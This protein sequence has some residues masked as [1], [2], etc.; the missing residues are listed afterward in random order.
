RW[1]SDRKLSAILWEPFRMGEGTRPAG[2]LVNPRSFRIQAPCRG[3]EPPIPP[4]PPSSHRR[5]RGI[6]RATARYALHRPAPAARMTETV[7]APPASTTAIASD[8]DARAR[9]PAGPG[10]ARGVAPAGSTALLRWNAP[11]LFSKRE[12]H[13]GNAA[14]VAPT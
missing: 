8:R 10:D 7:P 3:R 2:P 6:V 4:G 13:P 9:T 11:W 14:R 5:M 12:G 1:T